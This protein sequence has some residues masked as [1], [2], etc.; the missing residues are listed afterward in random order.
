MRRVAL[1]GLTTF[2]RRGG[3]GERRKGVWAALL[4]VSLAA[5]AGVAVG[6]GWGGFE[7]SVRFGHGVTDRQRGHLPPLP[8]DVRGSKEDKDGAGVEDAGLSAKQRS[9]ETDKLWED[10]SAAVEASALEKARSLL[11]EYVARTDGFGC[12]DEWEAPA[13]CR[14]RRNSALDRLDALAAL[15]CGSDA[16]H[17][18]SYLVARAAYDA[19]LEG[20]AVSPDEQ[21][22]YYSRPSEKKEAE[23]RIAQ[24]EE[25]RAA[26]MQTWAGDVEGNLSALAHDPNLADNAA[27]LRAAGVYGA[28]QPGDAGEAFESV[29]ARYPKSEKRE[30]ALYMAGRI[31]MQSSA[32][33]PGDG[34]TATS[35]DPCAGA[36]C[37]DE[38]WT[39]ARRDFTR[40]L[41][42]YPKG[43]YATDARGWLAYLDLRVGDTS[44][45]LVEYYRLLA[46]ADD[47]A[48]RELAARSLRL[49]RGQ[50]DE[51]DMKRV[52]A[53]LEDEPRAALA[54]AYHNLYNYA[55]G[56]YLNVPEVADENPYQSEQYSSEQY[57]W[58]EHKTQALRERAQRR[59][60]RRV[61][62]FAARLIGR[63]PQ[64]GAGGAFVVRLAEAQLELGD[65]RAALGASRRAI[66]AGL[67][68][69]E[70]A[71]ALWVEGVAEYRLKDYAAARGTLTRL[72]E[73]FP[74]GDLTK[75]ARELVATV[76]EDAGD[77]EGA[78]EQYFALGYDPDVAYFMDVLLTP[79][80]VASFVTRHANSP[81]RDELLYALGLRYLRAGRYAEARA[82]LSRVRTTADSYDYDDDYYNP[83]DEGGPTHP[84]LHLR[85]RFWDEY[86]EGDGEYLTQTDA[87]DGPTPTRDTRVYSD[88]MLRD[89]KTLDDLERLQQEIERA[90]GD[91]A[92]AEATY[93]MASY[94]YEGSLL[95]YNPAAWRGMRAEMLGSLNETNYRSPNEAQVVWRYEQ[96]HE[97]PA[98][99]LALYL[100][101]VR[102]YPRTSAARDSLYTAILCHQRLSEFNRYWRDMY[103]KGLYA[104]E[105]LVTLADLRREYPQ[106]R[107]P[108][109]GDWKPSAR[110]VDGRPAW[111]APAKPKPPTGV[112]RVRWK[113][114]LAQWRVSQ[115]W[116]LFG[117]IYGGR[118]RHWTLVALHW[119]VV[120][121]VAS[122]VLLIFR[123]TRRTRRFMYKQLRRC[124]TR[125][126][127]H[128]RREVYAPTCS[129]AAHLP[130]TRHESLRAAAGETAHRILRLALNERGRAA[131]ALNLFTHGLLTVL[132]WAVL[133][134]V[135][136]G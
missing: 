10:A 89:M 33:Y 123:L 116:K 84:K 103:G 117:E 101:V 41:D 96:E 79:E 40:L 94:F 128:R 3:E 64:A 50:A 24:K 13:N 81:R 34:A 112:E 66:A 75:G 26:G 4:V 12:G 80:Q 25:E 135:K 130:Y 85:Y 2:A 37:R 59:E 21:H 5:C 11:R 73:E 67:A 16:G 83:S 78:L 71:Q 52:E 27:Y 47:R 118:V 56:Y 121:L 31:A 44:G 42:E 72:A 127:A 38:A 129:Y 74:H 51:E 55:P 136:A 120:A 15:E 29:A 104:G 93:Q 131:L 1:S 86:G 58:Q 32:T 115:G 119:L 70:R 46:G 107:L 23:E 126:R 43:R 30:A 18:K 45:A 53:A 98:R 17:V 108:A 22:Q 20:N 122:L 99:A 14:E 65:A 114:R 76:A 106:Y 134:A 48:G 77:L 9:A 92:K 61:A 95:F 49:V 133:W 35:E 82:T 124:C 8:F 69:D 132:L 54:Y 7:N 62:D 28:G 39:K 6:C 113:M 87:P 111:P 105:R 36:D 102:L 68:P 109:V 110:T 91:E 19:W 90:Q 125:G 88:W 63:Y 100:E 57:R 97:A 60:L